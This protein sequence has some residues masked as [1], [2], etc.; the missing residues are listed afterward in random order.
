[1]FR[2]CYWG[3]VSNVCKLCVVAVQLLV[4][5]QIPSPARRRDISLSNTANTVCYTALGSSAIVWWLLPS[6]SLEWL[7]KYDTVTVFKVEGG[8]IGQG[9]PEGH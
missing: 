3:C 4:S 7:L 1:M 2:G 6:L 5:R 8:Q 9:F